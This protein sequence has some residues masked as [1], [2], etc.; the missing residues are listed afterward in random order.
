MCIVLISFR[1]WLHSYDL[2]PDG[3]YK[4]HN[5]AFSSLSESGFIPTNL[6]EREDSEFLLRFSSLS[7]S[8]F[9]PTP[10]GTCEFKEYFSKFSSLSE[11][12]F[13]PTWP[14]IQSTMYG[15]L[16]VL[17]SFR[18]WLHSYD[19]HVYTTKLTLDVGSHLFQR[20]ASFLPNKDSTPKHGC[21]REGGVLISF[22]E[23]LHSYHQIT[24]V[25]QQKEQYRSHLFQRVASF[26]LMK[27][28][29][30]SM[31]NV[32]CS[33]LFQRVASFLLLLNSMNKKWYP[34]EFSSLS[35]SG[36]IPT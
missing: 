35:E 18:E 34:Q 36:F 22:R 7:E 23:W 27:L 26:L 3:T 17:I 10:E 6:L 9:I 14:S 19:D 25:C 2:M 8:G 20:V 11:S 1:E 16:K 12:G 4:V 24:M 15:Q 32:W 5:P 13:I 31:T 29:W 30:L 21:C 33:H 28:N